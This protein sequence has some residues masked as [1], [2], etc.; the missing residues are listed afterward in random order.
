MAEQQAK[1]KKAV[2]IGIVIGVLDILVLLLGTSKLIHIAWSVG[3]IGLITFLGI[4][5]LVNY[6]SESPA[7]DRGEMRKAIAGSFIA[8]YFA[9][10]SLLTFTGFSP[11][12]EK[13]AETIIGHFTYLVGIVVIFYFGSSGVR[14]YLKFKERRHNSKEEGRIQEKK[15]KTPTTRR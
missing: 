4:L 9:L 2:R 13:L 6:L 11:S 14:E 8:V 7:L 15:R 3:S 1:W 5:M 10:V 12:S